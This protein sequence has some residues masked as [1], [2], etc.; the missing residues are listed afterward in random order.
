MRMYMLAVRALQSI[1]VLICWRCRFLLPLKRVRACSR[2]S[3]LFNDATRTHA[4]DMPRENRVH[5][6]PRRRI[7]YMLPPAPLSFTYIVIVMLC[8]QADK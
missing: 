6:H 3:S 5:I 8:E 2:E 7:K 4:C 1:S